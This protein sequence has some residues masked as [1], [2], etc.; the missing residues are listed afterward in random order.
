MLNDIPVVLRQ[1]PNW[2]CWKSIVRDGKATKVPFNAKTG[3]FAKADDPATWTSYEQAIAAA[4]VLNDDT[5]DGV[6]FELGGTNIVGIDF[7]NAITNKG[8]VDPYALAILKILGSPYTETSPSGTGLH[9]FVECDVLPEGG[10]K[11]SQGHIGIEIYH[12]REGGRYFTR[13]TQ[14]D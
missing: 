6:G 9:A 2:V 12:G 10:R 4:D 1:R 13:L 5:Y 14:L 11:L 3:G 8:I 7:D